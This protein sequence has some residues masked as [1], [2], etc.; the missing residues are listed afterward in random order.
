MQRFDLHTH[1][2]FSDGSHS[3]QELLFKAK[4][5]ELSGLSITDHDSIEAY[6]HLPKTDLMIGVGVEFSS[7]LGDDSVH[8]LGYDFILD[9]PAI[10]ALC[11]RHVQRR[12]C[13]NQAILK[14]LKQLGFSLSEDE[15][16]TRFHDRSVGRPHIAQMLVDLG[17]TSSI[18]QAFREFLAE[19][20]KA[21]AQGESV[22][23]EETIAVIHQA[24]GKA[25]IAHPH[26]IKKQKILKALKQLPFDGLEVYYA[27]YSA[28]QI[29][30][31]QKLA[32]E[33][34]WLSSGGSDFHGD[35]KTFNQ[36][37]SSWV[38]LELFNQ[39]FQRPLV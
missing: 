37:G 9:H 17:A 31:W 4:Q 28:A 5:L 10:T 23:V 21:Y 24:E 1:T 22:S 35:F 2:N 11:H 3:P 7:F 18:E 36:L 27:K 15:L 16:Y 14:N 33:K 20:K 12:L 25:F 38:D 19:G 26:L 29:K 39:I 34:H 30:P 6:Y 13:R 8:I 32:L